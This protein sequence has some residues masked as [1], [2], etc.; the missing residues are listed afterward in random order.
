[1]G[2]IGNKCGL[3]VLVTVT[4]LLAALLQPVLPVKADPGWEFET[5]DSAANVRAGMSSSIA[6]DSSGNPHISYTYVNTTFNRGDLK[7]ASYNGTD[8]NTETVVASDDSYLIYSTSLAL[9]SSNQPHISFYENDQVNTEGSFKYASYNGTDWQIQTIESGVGTGGPEYV[10]SIAIDGFDNP[11]ISFSHLQTTPTITRIIKY[12]SYN[13][14]S[15]NTEIVA[16]NCSTSNSL[17]LDS[18]DVPHISYNG[19]TSGSYLGYASYNGTDWNTTQV[20]SAW[21]TGRYNSIAIDSND[22]PHI[23]HTYE[24]TGDYIGYLKYA[25]YNGTDWHR[26][27]VDGGSAGEDVGYWTS[28][29]LDGSDHPHISYIDYSGQYSQYSLK[30][31]SYNGTAWNTE[32]VDTQSGPW[33]TSLALDSCGYPHISYYDVTSGSTGDLK[34]ARFIPAP[35]LAI[36]KGGSA[37]S[38]VGDNITY[39]V[40]IT[41]IGDVPLQKVSVSDNR[42]GVVTDISGWFSDTLAVGASEN[43]TYTYTVQLGDPNPLLNIV[44]AVYGDG[45]AGCFPDLSVSDNHSVTLVQPSIEVTKT[46][47]NPISKVGDNVTFTITIENTGDWPLI[48][49]SVSDNLSVSPEPDTY[50][51]FDSIPAYSSVSGNFTYTVQLAD[52]DPLGNMVIVHYHPEG[53]SNDI[54]D[55]ATCYVDLR[56]PN[57]LVTKYIAAGIYRAGD[58]IT[59]LLSINNTSTDITLVKDSDSI[60]D[61]LAGDITSLFSDNITAGGSDNH[62]YT[63]TVKATDP[64]PLVNDVTARY[65]PEGLTNDIFDS[66]YATVFLLPTIT[67]VTPNQG[68][69][70]QTLDVTINGSQ[71]NRVNA[72]DFGAGIT[73]NSL[74]A[75]PNQI[76]ANLSIDANA[77]PGTRDVTVANPTGSD[78]LADAFTVQQSQASVNT[79]TGTG[80][81]TFSTSD[82]AITTLTA[83]T[84]TPC[85]TLAGYSFP[86][87]FFSFNITGI[88]AG[89]TVT[90][91]ITLPSA[92]PGAT[93]YWKCQNGQWVNCTSLLGS[94]D[95]DNIITLTIEDGGLGDGDGTANGTI[96]DPGGPATA[97]TAA[98][99]A[100]PGSSTGGHPARLTSPELKLKYLNINPQQ[101]SA[102]QPV[103]IST[104]V[105]NTGGEPGSYNVVLRVNGKVEEVRTVKVTPGIAQPVRFTVTRAQPGTYAVDIGNQKSKFTI[106]GASRGGAGAG[107]GLI[108]AAATMVLVLVLM[109]GLLVIYRRN[110]L[111]V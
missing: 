45:G 77:A 82:G 84:T 66:T 27:T 62:T 53:L 85:G 93:Q 3:L 48:R 72:V 68:A 17:A 97:V 37:V 74:T 87:G 51:P 47:V 95:G 83:A 21:H 57:I 14:T 31:A 35:G 1:M 106:V 75:G 78:T 50:A 103:V 59:Y 79:A 12:A 38:K 80:T 96:V 33:A 70:G 8:W 43:R 29:A 52:P 28:L 10:S 61:S 107:D 69:P 108:L 23:S 102:N 56:H 49:D 110:R 101:A 18:N 4:A 30:Y 32:T 26:D 81:A 20:T 86:H 55:N 89:S 19:E 76:T 15:W 6:L 63:Y 22:H 2:K 94:N 71:L 36:S 98:Q 24:T 100:S 42:S 40:A 11:H 64:D 44:D 16:S 58:S 39:W 91:T 67:S 25:S 13:G 60:T 9:D 88:P 111:Q 46:S 99:S 92:M 105:I 73:V 90:I 109:L 65:H 7:Y 41:N 34:Y 5:L 104:N 54:T